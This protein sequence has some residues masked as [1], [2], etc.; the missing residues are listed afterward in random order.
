MPS[1][2]STNVNARDADGILVKSHTIGL[3]NRLD[4]HRCLCAVGRRDLHELCG[5]AA[6]KL[7]PGIQPLSPRIDDSE[8]VGK[9]WGDFCTR[10]IRPLCIADRRPPFN[11]AAEI[12]IHLYRPRL[13]GQQARGG[14]RRT[15]RHHSSPAHQQHRRPHSAL[16][17]RHYPASATIPPTMKTKGG[18]RCNRH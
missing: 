1:E 11:I 5:L 2:S 10:E 15:P 7:R 18:E 6:N 9:A 8:P 12:Q 16:P 14:R 3:G 13:P 4:P 17:L